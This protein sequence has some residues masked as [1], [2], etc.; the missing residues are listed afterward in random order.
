[1]TES[2]WGAVSRTRNSTSALAALAALL[3]SLSAH[4]AEVAT[5]SV[6][7]GPARLFVR[8]AP[9][10]AECPGAELLAAELQ[11]LGIDGTTA[12]AK[13]I[14]VAITPSDAGFTALVTVSGENGGVRDLRAEGPGCT[15]LTADLEATLALLLDKKQQ[16]EARN[17]PATPA[18]PV[19]ATAKPAPPAPPP[20]KKPTSA[21]KGNASALHGRAELGAGAAIALVAHPT[22]YF[23]AAVWLE[24]PDFSAALQLFST[25]SSTAELAPGTVH[26]L[27]L[28][29]VL[30]GC[31]PI[32]GAHGRLEGSVCVAGAV[33]A[34]R[35]EAAG[36]V[37]SEPA[38]YRPWYALG[39]AG[40]L[41]GPIARK[42]SWKVDA[43]LLAPL[44]HESFVIGPLGTAFETPVVGALAGVR[45]G[46]SIW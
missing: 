46:M 28:G 37:V 21:K 42:F 13:E 23:D 27:L 11:P 31:L 38:A 1:M 35:G 8:R 24:H 3:A 41:G 12:A 32:F 15:R 25:T 2:I 43:T 40:T 10:A 45:F 5:D 33:A 17:A 20:A 29:G 34:L 26:V 9:E 39:A 30:K 7:I 36:Y 22:A 4:A 44:H 14:T 6:E 19:T 16:T 18:A